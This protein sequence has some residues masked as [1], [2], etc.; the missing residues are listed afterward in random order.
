MWKSVDGGEG[1][2]VGGGQNN[3]AAGDYAKAEEA[4]KEAIL[5]RPT[6]RTLRR[7][8]VEVYFRQTKWEDAIRLLKRRSP[9][10]E[11]A[12]EPPDPAHPR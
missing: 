12:R 8:L 1:A 3:S 7:N 4:L 9:R 10:S 11:R 6:D 2:S 5:E